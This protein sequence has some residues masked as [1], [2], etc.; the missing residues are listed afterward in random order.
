MRKLIIAAATAATVGTLGLT[1]TAQAQSATP[2]RVAATIKKTVVAGIPASISVKQT[3]SVKCTVKVT[4]LPGPVTAGTSSSVNHG[5]TVEIEG[6]FPT[7]GTKTITIKF[8]AGGT[9]TTDTLTVTI[10]A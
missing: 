5:C 7:P 6:V 8:T 1:A 4:G 2:H 3:S 10:L 9:T